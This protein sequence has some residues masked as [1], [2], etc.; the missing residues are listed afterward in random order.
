VAGDQPAR[1]SRADLWPAAEGLDA[2]E[3]IYLSARLLLQ[4][5]E[6]RTPRDPL[7]IQQPF[8]IE[9]G[10]PTYSIIERLEKED[11]ISARRR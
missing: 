4:V 6:L 8:T 11:F 3:R 7:G 9:L 5:D 1:Q 10:E 2:F